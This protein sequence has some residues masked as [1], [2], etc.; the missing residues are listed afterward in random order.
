MEAGTLLGAEVA[1]RYRLVRYLGDGP[2]GPSFEASTGEGASLGVKVVRRSLLSD[3]TLSRYLETATALSAIRDDHLVATRDVAFDLPQG[4]VV[5]A[6]DLLTGPN[7]AALLARNA[8]LEALAALRIVAQACSGIGS[9]HAVE[10][11]HRNIKP[12]NVF[13]AS[14]DGGRLTVR[15]CD[16]AVALGSAARALRG[17]WQHLRYASPEL[18]SGAK[19]ASADAGRRS[20]VFSLGAVLYALLTGAPPHAEASSAEALMDALASREVE[21]LQ[22]RASWVSASIARVV[23][24]AISRDPVRRFS[25]AQALGTALRELTRGDDSVTRDDLVPLDPALCRTEE[26]PASK[27]AVSSPSGAI[28]S[29]PQRDPLLGHRLGGR[30]RVLRALGRGGMGAVY[31]VE[32][33]TGEH[34]A[35]KVISREASRG[36]TQSVARFI[37]EAHSVTKIDDVHVTRTIELGTDMELGVPFLV[38]ELLHGRDLGALFKERGAIEPAPLLRVFTQAA[39]GLS[40]AHRQGIV[41]RDVK[42][43]NIFLHTSND[44]ALTVKICDFGLAKALQRAEDEAPSHELTRTGGILGT[45]MYMS[46]EHA[47]NPREVDAR[48]DIWSLC[49]SLYEGL[50]GQKLW[51]GAGSTLA[52]L[53]LAI[54]TREFPP[55][56]EAAPWVS[57]PVAAIV[58]RGLERDPDDRWPDLDAMIA[59]MAPHIGSGTDVSLEQIAGVDPARLSARAS[60]APRVPAGRSSAPTQADR[61]ANGMPASS[62]EQAP[63]RPSPH[64]ESGLT[65]PPPAPSVG[66]AP[67]ARARWLV[68]AVAAGA[69]ALVAV[70]ATTRPWRGGHVPVPANGPGTAIG[71]AKTKECAKNAECVK[72]HGGEPWICGPGGRCAPLASE[73]CK[74]LAEPGAAENDETVWFGTMF[75]LSGDLADVGAESTNAVELARR[76]FASVSAGLPPSGGAPAAPIGLVTCDDSTNAARVAAHLTQDV[77]VPAVIGFRASNEVIDL[78]SRFFV[79]SRTLTIATLN[80]S[81]LITKVPQPA[82]GPRL[83]WR[84]AA[85]YGQTPEVMTLVI[86]QAIEPDLR[87]TGGL[88]LHERLR[89]AAI[90]EDTATGLGAEDSLLEELRINDRRAL[91]SHDDFRVYRCSATGATSTCEQHA[92]AIVAFRPHVIIYVLTAAN[93]VPLFR[94]L[95]ERWPS[96]APFRPRYL[97]N[98]PL[99]GLAPFLDEKPERRRRFLG[100]T[101]PYNDASAKLTRRYNAA[102]HSHLEETQIPAAQYDAFYLLAF[103][104]FAEK[105]RPREGT[106]LA[107]TFPRLLPPAE[108]IEVGPSTLLEVFTRLSRGEPVALD[109]ASALLDLDL[110][111]GERRTDFDVLCPGVGADGRSS[112]SIASGLRY[113]HI[114]HVLEGTRACP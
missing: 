37:R 68:R 86:R 97:E 21:A 109:G 70:V 73:D 114:H 72:G 19:D 69:L 34:F 14:D 102:F 63:P 32:G 40:A 8:P 107:A 90:L 111:T 11:V 16:P 105:E 22:G 88:A 79:P 49:A 43:A 106:T 54:C 24:R 85:S 3:E 64:S 44:G 35:A 98:N 95:E 87:A 94:E 28:F 67:P 45:P 65:G 26:A 77:H 36:D 62:D 5:F 38:M 39:M 55:L 51:T 96:D 4:F 6:R 110:G 53:M 2:L 82:G 7:L 57:R 18:V 9:A 76:E 23:D 41:H 78:A 93:L 104:A 47:T 80:H 30:Y 74:V 56:A 33:P 52:E 13:L 101:P 25:S 112:G 103:A 89:A 83:V 31:E 58:E 66:D 17:S 71:A 27:R 99:D 48:A 1:A 20:D 12:S 113:D 75:P 46:P 91:D 10:L 61:P 92:D 81:P 60:F 29:M 108:S 84:L 42:P 100:L 15:I 50:S 59:A